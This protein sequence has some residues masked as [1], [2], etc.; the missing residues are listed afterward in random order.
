MYNRTNI[1]TFNYTKWGVSDQSMLDVYRLH[2][3]RKEDM[4]ASCRW[5]GAQCSH[6]DFE[7]TMTDAGICYTFNARINP[8]NKVNATGVKNGLKLVVNIEQYQYTKGPNNAV[9]LK[10]RLHNQGVIP[11]ETNLP[12]PHGD[13][14]RHRKLRYFSRYSQAACYREC[15]TDFVV[16]TCGCRDYYMPPFNTDEPPVCNIS[17]YTSC[18]L[19]TIE[20][21]KKNMSATCVC[22]KAC[23]AMHYKASLSY[24]SANQNSQNRIDLSARFLN[25]VGK[26]L[27]KSLNT[28][29]RMLPDRREGNIDEAGRVLIDAAAEPLL[30]VFYAKL[31]DHY[32]RTTGSEKDAMRKYFMIKDDTSAYAN[33]NFLELNI[34]MRDLRVQEYEQLEAFTLIDLLS[35]IGGSMGSLIGASVIT[36]FEAVD[37]FAI[38]LAR[39]KRRPQRQPNQEA[40]NEI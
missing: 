18:L 6:E 30:R 36:L 40:E 33:R 28:K 22:P 38:T 1:S 17:Q 4:I 11:M 15:V 9:G 37:V 13:C 39:K 3:H 20:P 25:T 27:N 26:N 2:A 14:V 7:L 8:N 19:P 12:P 31:Y 23:G 24:A 16:D 32:K 29:E 35:N 10:F 34:Y 21:F 5:K